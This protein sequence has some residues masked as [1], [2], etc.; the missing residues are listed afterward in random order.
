MY[1][2]PCHTNVS[3]YAFIQN[4]FP[5]VIGTAAK[6]VAA[7]H[8]NYCCVNSVL[9]LFFF[10][11]RDQ[12]LTIIKIKSSSCDC[13][14]KMSLQLRILHETPTICPQV[15][16]MFVA[17]FCICAIMI[18]SLCNSSE[19]T[20]EHKTAKFP[21]FLQLDK[22]PF[23]LQNVSYP[24]ITFSINTVLALITISALCVYSN[25][26]NGNLWPA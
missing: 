26:I 10:Y 9:F 12:L 13:E 22:P 20:F 17:V 4:N 23:H 16:S 11:K 21:K 7:V 24:V 6:M 2:R 14:H 3:S 25:N 15:N 5:C 19:R 1:F 8:T 18:G